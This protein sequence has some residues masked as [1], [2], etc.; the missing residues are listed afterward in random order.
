MNEKNY[1]AKNR[2]RCDEKNMIDEDTRGLS[3]YSNSLLF[4]Q[5]L[6]EGHIFSKLLD[7]H[8][9]L[10][11][12]LVFENKKKNLQNSDWI[13]CDGKNMIDEDTQGLSPL[14]QLSCLEK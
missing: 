12:G 9:Y 14:I 6:L 7:L 4:G 8:P 2:S 11:V 10:L 13:Q 5:Q 1:E 3:S